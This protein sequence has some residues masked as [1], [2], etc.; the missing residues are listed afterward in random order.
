MRSKSVEVKSARKVDLPILL[1]I[2]NSSRAGVGCYSGK[3]VDLDTFSALI[4]GE[5]VHVAVLDGTI[6]G[7]ISVWTTDRFIHHLYV[8]PLY[9]GS[10]IGSILLQL[11]EELYG[12]PL[13]LKCDSCNERAQR[14][15]RRKGWTPTEKGVG[16][17][18][19][20]DRFESPCA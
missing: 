4:D 11:C 16:T 18:G 5:E 13:S 9:Q 20:W 10:G 2:F 1:D 19:S 7:F 17:D 3:A 6:V 12:L 8:A 15:Y 14:F